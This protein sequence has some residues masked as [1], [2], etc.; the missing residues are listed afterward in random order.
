MEKELYKRYENDIKNVF[1]KSLKRSEL[2]LDELDLVE[3]IRKTE[4]YLEIY[5]NTEGTDLLKIF[6]E[7][8]LTSINRRKTIRALAMDLGYSKRTVI[9]FKKKILRIFAFIKDKSNQR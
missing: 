4:I 3:V 5:D 7:L 8:F 9:R 2:S 6:I 1:S